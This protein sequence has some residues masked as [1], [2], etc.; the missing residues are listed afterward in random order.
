MTSPSLRLSQTIQRILKESTTSAGPVGAVFASVDRQG[1]YLAY[2]ASGKRSLE[3]EDAMKK[4]DI[5]AFFSVTKLITT[6]ACMQLVERNIVNLDDAEIINR[7]LP[8]V[9]NAKMVDGSERKGEEITLRML[10][11]HTA[12]Y[13]YPFFNH[14]LKTY[15][16]E[17]DYSSR[18]GKLENIVQPL[19]HS[20]GTAFSYGIS[21]DWA[22]ELVARLTSQRLGDYVRT[23][24]F[25]PLGCQDIAFGVREK[26]KK[27]IGERMVGMNVRSDD[28]ALKPS[29]HAATTKMTIDGEEPYHIGGGGLLGTAEDFLK[30]STVMIN[31]GR[32]ANGARIL[33]PETVKM[34]YEDQIT[35]LPLSKEGLHALDVEIPAANPA[36]TYP[37]KLMPGVKKGWGLSF[38]ITKDQLPT[39][40][41][42]NSIWWAGLA[43]L[44]WMCDPVKGIANILC[45]Q[46][47]PFYD[48]EVLKLWFECEKAVYDELDG[49]EVNS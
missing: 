49:K 25:D 47:F 18:V 48:P 44:Y 22:G 20:P 26:N 15:L 9:A 36:L 32:G 16:Q 41:S 45:T 7:I 1:N 39:G 10:L 28:G 33:R 43:N 5:F 12:G 14:Q 19:V 29:V 11:T 35:H 8:E 38:V 17:H 24:I 30:I 21:L 34:M 37:V 4:D 46:S 31:S 23:H 40:R 2:N 42:P 27:T 3:C 6:I 13:G